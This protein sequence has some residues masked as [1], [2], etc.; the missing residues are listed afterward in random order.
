VT[1]IELIA[2]LRGAEPGVAAAL[3]R[4]WA[5][6]DR[7]ADLIVA[8]LLVVPPEA[9]DGCGILPAGWRVR[10]GPTAPG[11]WDALLSGAGREGRPVLALTA[12]VQPGLE[13]AGVM[14]ALLDSDAMYGAAAARVQC[15]DGCC[16]QTLLSPGA[17]PAQWLPLAALAEFPAHDLLGEILSPCMVLKPLVLTD[18]G[19]ADGSFD[20]LAGVILHRLITARRAGFRTVVANRAVVRVASADCR[21]GSASADW[22][23]RADAARLGPLARDVDQPWTECRGASN[24]LFERLTGQLL[25][26]GS[27]AVRPRLL[28][29]M[30]NLRAMFNG[31]AF[32]AIG[33][34]RGLYQ[35]DLGWDVSVWAHPDGAPFHDFEAAFPGW[36]VVTDA[37]G[38]S[39]DV[40]LRLSQ[41]WH[42]QEMVD[43]HLCARVNAYLILDSIAWDVLYVAPPRLDGTWRFLTGSADGLLFISQFSEQRFCARFP[44]AAATARGVCHLSF[45]PDDYT[46]RDLIGAPPGDYILIV[47]NHLDHKDVPATV[48]SIA[49]AFPFQPIEVLGPAPVRSPRI[50]THTSGNLADRDVH[51]LYASA[52]M[53]VFPSFYEGFGFPV[54][55]ALA[56]GRTMLA[57]ES[58]LLHEVA[59]RCPARGRLIGYQQRDEVVEAIGRLLHGEPVA[60]IPVGRELNGG[61]PRSWRQV[62]VEID[63]FLRGLL[64]SASTSS[65]RARDDMVSQALAYRA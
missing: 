33:A 23:P 6:E 19:E 36:R 57:R 58:S 7:A 2:D 61:R 48:G 27:G 17:G 12:P 29:D 8:A 50:R 45:D 44:R 56:Y 34:A 24:A 15:L 28:L 16:V 18:F 30:R 35:A 37:P 47:G 10:S 41:P 26:S 54:V 51:A 39:F 31:T 55:T 64:A 52:R 3:V 53:V 40:A 42:I 38:A 5:V 60:E 11:F 20:S 65:W 9:R 1:Q 32:A 59:G 13:A 62:G 43:L 46:H 21:E 22:L 25:K 63:G 14:L 4:Q 49:S